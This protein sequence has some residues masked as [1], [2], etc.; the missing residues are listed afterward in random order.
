M[1]IL[2]AGTVLLGLASLFGLLNHHVLKLPFT[3]GL[4]V[5]GLT[6]SL[7]MLTVDALFPS[8]NLAADA[9]AAVTQVDFA[10]TVLYGML[11]I[12]LFAG[13]LHTD[14]ERLLDRAW[15]ILALA[16][17]GVV[18]STL[19]AA[20]LAWL[21]FNGLGLE[22]PFVWCLVFGALISPTDPIAVLGIMRSAGGPPSL[23]AKVVGESLFND[24]FGVVVFLV[25]LQI[26]TGGGHGE[27]M[28]AAGVVKL[29]LVEIVGGLILGGLVGFLAYLAIRSLN[30]SN[31]EILLSVAAV[32]ALNLVALKLHVSA[33]LA[34]VVAGLL[35]GNRGR[36]MAMSPQTKEHL[37]IVWHFIDEA[38]NAILF[39]LVGLEVFALTFE[40]PTFLAGL[41]LIPGVLGARAVAVYLPLTAL[42]ATIGLPDGSRRVL[43]WGGLKGGISVALAMSLPPSPVRDVLLMA[44]YL[45]VVFSIVVQGLTVGPLIRNIFQ[46]PTEA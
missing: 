10:E 12:L 13:A 1:F 28:S 7:M 25:L 22:I 39:L 2:E 27:A 19:V 38:L 17:L 8:L 46:R 9:R 24:G 33:P 44:T 29:L 4:L 36:F 15:P 30:A 45:T 40:L 14:I 37:D 23:E 6:A 21:T 16:T 11:S 34:A 41:I 31:L 35:L 26:A 3:I 32:L 43:I 18:L 5:S 42:K 20:G